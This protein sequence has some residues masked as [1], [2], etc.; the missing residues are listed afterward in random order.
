MESG[1]SKPIESAI[2]LGIEH[3]AGGNVTE[4][5]LAQESCDGHEALATEPV[6]RCVDAESA[7][8][9]P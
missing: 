3:E 7:R 9:H 8:S 2:S 4:T 6:T 1:V 5:R